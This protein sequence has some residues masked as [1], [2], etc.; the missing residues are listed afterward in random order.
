MG[1]RVRGWV[2]LLAL[3]LKM[4]RRGTHPGAASVTT[5][6]VLPPGAAST[7]SVRPHL[8]GAGPRPV[9]LHHTLAHLV[10]PFALAKPAAQR[11]AGRGGAGRAAMRAGGVSVVCRRGGQLCSR[12]CTAP[13]QTATRTIVTSHH[14]QPHLLVFTSNPMPCFVS[15]IPPVERV[16]EA[17]RVHALKREAVD[18]QALR[19]GPLLVVVHVKHCLKGGSF[20]YLSVY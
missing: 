5:A 13:C 20:G 6:A 19:R 8:R 17:R 10:P 9:H 3:A 4:A 15:P 11:P 1:A 16:V 18:L 14:K 2:S 12:R 7:P